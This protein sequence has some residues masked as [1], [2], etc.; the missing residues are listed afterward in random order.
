MTD[1]PKERQHLS[2]VVSNGPDP[3]DTIGVVTYAH[4]EGESPT[5]VVRGPATRLLNR[6]KMI[7]AHI[8]QHIEENL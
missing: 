2:L 7:L 3:V 6:L 5:V 4:Q 1:I 8:T